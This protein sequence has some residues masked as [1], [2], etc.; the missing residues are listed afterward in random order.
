LEA[1]LRT[2]SGGTPRPLLPTTGFKA[3]TEGEVK[4]ALVETPQRTVQ[5]RRSLESLYSATPTLVN[6]TIEVRKP[7]ISKFGTRLAGTRRRTF[8]TDSS[9]ETVTPTLVNPIK[10]ILSKR[11]STAEKQSPK[12]YAGEWRDDD[13]GARKSQV[14]PSLRSPSL[15]SRL[16]SALTPSPVLHLAGRNRSIESLS[17]LATPSPPTRSARHTVVTPTPPSRVPYPRLVDV[18]P[19]PRSHRRFDPVIIP[20]FSTPSPSPPSRN[21]LRA[22]APAESQSP[23]AKSYILNRFLSDTIAKELVIREEGKPPIH[24]V[25]LLF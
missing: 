11:Q 3:K 18:L 5:S 2:T 10:P 14:V 17:E 21:E 6:P 15:D 9:Q 13:L 23:K 7:P 16:T 19:T 24:F 22:G 8:Q 1:D 4:P 20:H 25:R 12:R